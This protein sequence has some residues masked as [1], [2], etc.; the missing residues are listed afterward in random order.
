ML[1]PTETRLSCPETQRLFCLVNIHRD[2]SLL[3]RESLSLWERERERERETIR[4]SPQR[5]FCLVQRHRASV[6]LSRGD[7]STLAVCLFVH[8]ILP[9][10]STTIFYLNIPPLYSKAVDP[11][12]L[13]FVV[14]GASSH[15][16]WV[17]VKVGCLCWDVI[18]LSLVSTFYHNILPQYSTLIFHHYIPRL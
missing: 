17:S 16:L 18:T 5:R 12:T 1:F 14:Y 11:D 7:Q 13:V 6:G 4:A 9:Q 8:H 3:S 15:Y 2:S 10:Y